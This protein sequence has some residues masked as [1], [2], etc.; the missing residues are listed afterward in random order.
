MIVKPTDKDG[1]QFKPLYKYKA[2]ILQILFAHNLPCWCQSLSSSGGDGGV[3]LQ[4]WLT[5]LPVIL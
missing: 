1:Q 3:L 4:Q 2:E 5:T